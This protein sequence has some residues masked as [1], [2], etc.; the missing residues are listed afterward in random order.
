MR[1]LYNGVIYEGRMVDNRS[2]WDYIYNNIIKSNDDSVNDLSNLFI[3]YTSLDKVG[4]NPSSIYGTPNG[5][6]C[7][8]L[9][10][11]S[12]VKGNVPFVSTDPKY[13]TVFS[14]DSSKMLK[15]SDVTRI[16]YDNL[17]SKLT[18]INDEYK[19]KLDLS[20]HVNSGLFN[21]GDLLNIAN[22]D[23]IVKSFGGVLWNVIRLLSIEVAEFEKLQTNVNV[24]SRLITRLGYIGVIDECAGIIHKNEECQAVVFSK[25]EITVIDRTTYRKN[26]PLQSN[27]RLKYGTFEWL[28][29]MYSSGMYGDDQDKFIRDYMKC[30]HTS[31]ELSTLLSTDDL[32]IFSW[33]FANS[34]VS[35]FTTRLMKDF[36]FSDFNKINVF[37]I[38]HYDIIQLVPTN[39]LET[40]MPMLISH[41]GQIDSHIL[42]LIFKAVIENGNVLDI[43]HR[44]KPSN[45]IN[46]KLQSVLFELKF[47]PTEDELR[48][49]IKEHD[50]LTE[51]NVNV[52]D[53]LLDNIDAVS[54]IYSELY[55]RESDISTISQSIADRILY[56]SEY[57]HM[58]TSNVNVRELSYEDMEEYLDEL[59]ESNPDAY[60]DALEELELL[61]EAILY[62]GYIYNVLR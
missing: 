11:Y 35:E 32:H 21:L 17:I 26:A 59:K 27:S 13:V 45:S 44:S 57:D 51:N 50:P 15:I 7:Y 2:T 58:N 52:L 39:V 22:K 62:E 12:S 47:I 61:T 6:Y 48:K 23:A 8:T 16:E 24:W 29:S 37:N 54:E 14:A 43:V 41:L 60:I 55:N 56:I 38:G 49:Y 4:I 28:H 40:L 42:N 31:S 36:T 30:V 10:Y 3:T 33:I 19:A 53:I 9:S 5:I 34:I 20:G 18:K 25:S 46:R 1:Y